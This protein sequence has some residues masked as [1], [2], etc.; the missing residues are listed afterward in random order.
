MSLGDGYG[1]DLVVDTA[2]IGETLKLSM[3]AVRPA[4]QITKIGWGTEPVDFSLD[5]IVAKAVT[6]QGHFSH[7]W[8]VW[9]HCLTLISKKLIDLNGIITHE[10]SIEQWEKAFELVETKAA[11]KVV[12][13]PI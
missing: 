3:Q 4:G 7:T 1:A 6:L 5:P 11:L 8:D 12:L 9:E 13:K 2:G 10:F